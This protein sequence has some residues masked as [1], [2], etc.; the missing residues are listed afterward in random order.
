MFHV[1]RC[2]MMDEQSITRGALALTAYKKISGKPLFS[3]P[4]DKCNEFID[5]F[6]R[7]EV[8]TYAPNPRQLTL[9]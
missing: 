6:F 7:R 9:F 8:K 2:T 1:Y 4:L 3:G 5:D